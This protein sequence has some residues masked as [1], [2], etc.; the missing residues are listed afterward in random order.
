MSLFTLFCILVG[1]VLAVVITVVVKRALA[2]MNR[3]VDE[4]MRSGVPANSRVMKL[5]HTGTSVSFG[6]DRHVRLVVSLEVHPNGGAPYHGHCE[7]LLSELVIPSVQPGSWLQLRVDPQNPQRLAI[8]GAGAV[9]HHGAR[10]GAAPGAGYP[11]AGYPGAGYPGAPLAMM[12]GSEWDPSHFQAKAGKAFSGGMWMTI[13]IGAITTIP[14]LIVFADWSAL[15][16]GD[17]APNGGYCKGAARCCK[18]VFDGAETCDGM[19][20]LPAAGCKSAF[21]S[22]AESAKRTGKTCE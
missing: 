5:Q 19:E 11:G 13:I 6:A 20:D 9:P 17:G 8:A 3:D 4:L 14:L 18:V 10:G 22:Y 7:P 15:F 21:E 12:G 2:G 16:G 1:P